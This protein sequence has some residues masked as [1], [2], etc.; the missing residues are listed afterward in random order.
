MGDTFHLYDSDDDGLSFFANNDGNG[1]ARLKKVAGATFVQFENDF[2]KEIS[3]NFN[4]ETDLV[5]VEEQ[6]APKTQ[7]S[8][9]PNP[10][11]NELFAKP[12][13][14]G[15]QL[16]WEI[17]DLNGKVVMSKSQNLNPGELIRIETDLFSSGMYTLLIT[18]GVNRQTRRWVKE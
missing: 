1:Q 9:Y 2:G 7:L 3:H 15:N 13:N 16:V 18:D 10:T 12:V 17:Y 6:N 11:S 8:V 5:S 14:F 4:W